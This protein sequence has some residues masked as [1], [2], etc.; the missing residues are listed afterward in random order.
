MNLK[1]PKPISFQSF[2]NGMTN[3]V[4]TSNNENQLVLHHDGGISANILKSG[5]NQ[6][7]AGAATNEL[8]VKKGKYDSFIKIGK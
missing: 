1:P 8:W 4:I 2:N 7:K 6:A 5:K 3:L